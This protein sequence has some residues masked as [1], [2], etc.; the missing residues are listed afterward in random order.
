[1]QAQPLSLACLGP[2]RRQRQCHAVIE[3]RDAREGGVKGR[4][5]GDDAHVQVMPV[6]PFQLLGGMHGFDPDTDGGGGLLQFPYGR[7]Q[8]WDGAIAGHDSDP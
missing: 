2:V 3:Y 5:P 1:M 8:L 6:Q 7:R 4:T